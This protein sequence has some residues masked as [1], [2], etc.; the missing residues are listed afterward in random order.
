MSGLH[1]CL[2]M[3]LYD[4]CPHM[5]GFTGLVMLYLFMDFNILPLTLVSNQELHTLSV[6]LGMQINRLETFHN[7]KIKQ[8]A[9]PNHEFGTHR[10]G[11]NHQNQQKM[12][13][14]LDCDIGFQ[15][16][17]FIQKIKQNTK[18]LPKL[19]ENHHNNQE[20]KAN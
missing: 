17:Q 1:P 10:M 20:A 4:L 6:E 5:P 15:K 3:R 2:Q 11:F 14:F 8:K 12:V 18:R 9:V 16:S 7:Q 13:Q 19:R